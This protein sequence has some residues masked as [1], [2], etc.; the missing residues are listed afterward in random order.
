MKIVCLLTAIPVLAADS[1]LYAEENGL[2]KFLSKAASDA[3]IKLLEKAKAFE[4]STDSANGTIT[5][6]EPAK[7]VKVTVESF[8]LKSDVIR[9][10]IKTEGRFRL[11]S[12]ILYH[13]SG[14]TVDAEMTLKLNLS[15]EARMIKRDG[16]FF[17]KPSVTD[18]TFDLEIHELT[19]E[20]LSGGK[21]LVANL[22][23]TIV[24]N[25]KQ[26]ILKAINE[27]CEELKLPTKFQTMNHIDAN[28]R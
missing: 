12:T 22:L 24:A 28:E 5:P 27:A 8:E 17:V 18:F 6:I 9:A 10:K 14:I 2:T 16:S 19:P 23:E 15:L 20:S 3:A 11:N 1:R 25:Q 4:L 7:N 26:A 21:E 13:G